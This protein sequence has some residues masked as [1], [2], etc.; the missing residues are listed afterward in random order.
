MRK[1]R[2]NRQ[3]G[4]SIIEL[5]LVILIM[6]IIVL[7]GLPA[8]LDYRTRAAVSDMIV[9]VAGIKNNVAEFYILNN[10]WPDN[11]NEAGMTGVPT[12]YAN[13]G[14]QSIDV[15]AGGVIVITSNVASLEGDTIEFQPTF[16][17]NRVSWDCTGG[18]LDSRFRPPSCRTTP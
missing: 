3:G 17:D 1:A 8:Y 12:D 16:Q 18:T 6:S 4:F 5:M 7:I 10:D 9:A 11:M 13:K 14:V 2:N 15:N